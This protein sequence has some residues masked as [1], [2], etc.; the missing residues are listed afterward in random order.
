MTLDTL[1]E[2]LIAVRDEYG[3]DLRVCTPIETGPGRVGLGA[4]LRD[5][6]GWIC[7]V[8]GT[9]ESEHHDGPAL[10]LAPRGQLAHLMPGA[11]D[12]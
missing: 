5:L 4:D 3:G 12:D 1:I 2:K 8:E 10:V 6:Q 9:V 7:Q 11:S